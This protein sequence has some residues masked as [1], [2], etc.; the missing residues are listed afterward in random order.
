MKTSQ[1]RSPRKETEDKASARRPRTL[2][3]HPAFAPI[4]GGWG[5]LLGALVVLVLPLSVVD[6]VLGGNGLA[7]LGSQVQWLL[8]AL[9]A[10]AMGSIL[11]LIAVKLSVKAV[12]PSAPDN[13]I[14]GVSSL[15]RPIDPYNDL[16]SPS[17]DEPMSDSP[18][19]AWRL[20]PLEEP[21]ETPKPVEAAPASPPREL[22]LSQFAELPGRNAVW[23][24]ET[25]AEPH[26]ASAM[27][28]AP[29]PAPEPVLAPTPVPASAVAPAPVPPSATALARLRAVPPEELSTVQMVERFAAALH[30]HRDPATGKTSHSRVAASREAAL[31]EALKAL[32]TLSDQDS[33]SDTRKPL[34]DAMAQLQSRR[35]AA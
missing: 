6:Q 3:A 2:R 20:E 21:R 27:P 15:L 14:R 5:A 28:Q 1:F 29:T 18:L 25:V 17:F 10:A 24:D 31:A 7:G 30:E 32:A 16:G 12:A 33:P 11:Y 26:Q 34:R 8:A 22:D 4:L 9:A 23:V 13:L 19:A 35:G